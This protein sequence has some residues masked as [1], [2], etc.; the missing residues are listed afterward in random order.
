MAKPANRATTE[1]TSVAE[2]GRRFG[3][4]HPV[5]FVPVAVAKRDGIGSVGPAT[6]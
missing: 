4:P 3:S 1:P 6:L 2:S 5:H